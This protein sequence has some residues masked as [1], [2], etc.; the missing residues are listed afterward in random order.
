M[1]QPAGNACPLLQEEEAAAGRRKRRRGGAAAAA[2]EEGAPAEG[3]EEE[4]AEE[5]EEEE[6]DEEEGAEGEEPSH[7][8]D[9]EPEEGEEGE[10]EEPELEVGPFAAPSTPPLLPVESCRRVRFRWTQR[11]PLHSARA[12]AARLRHPLPPVCQLLTALLLMLGWQPFLFGR[13]GTSPW[14]Q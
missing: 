1:P 9:G 7:S 12:G 13:T 4:D 5:E 11:A 2:D 8:S 6:E 10:G 3:A 14:S